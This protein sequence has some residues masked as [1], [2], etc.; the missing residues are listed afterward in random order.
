MSFIQHLRKS[1]VENQQF[2]L[3]DDHGQPIKDALQA[4]QVSFPFAP[5][6]VKLSDPSG[7]SKYDCWTILFFYTNRNLDH[8]SYLQ[9][10][11]ALDQIKGKEMGSVSFMDRRDL[12][13]FLTGKAEHS[14]H[15]QATD[16]RANADDSS[17]F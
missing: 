3:W 10:C 13:D 6:K 15:V 1:I 17:V 16:R 7:Y 2:L 5:S 9:T 8:P 11:S 4:S 12:L 14:A